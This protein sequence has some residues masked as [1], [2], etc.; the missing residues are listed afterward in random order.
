MKLQRLKKDMQRKQLAEKQRALKEAKKLNE[1]KQQKAA[2]EK[3]LAEVKKKQRE[4]EKSQKIAENLRI[5]KAK[6]AQAMEEQKQQAAA[7]ARKA[8][9]MSEAEKF[10]VLIVTAISKQWILPENVD[11]SLS[12]QFHIRLAPDGTV[13]D[14][15]LAQSSGDSILDRSAQTAIY[16]A[17]PLPVPTDAQLF[18]MFRSIRLTV[19]PE[20]VRG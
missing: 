2:E 10:K 16:K 3:R 6:E 11:D 20:N 4:V 14:V 13:L 18:E 8:Q 5:Q 7:R 17:S 12:S 9:M 15:Q 1:L 19:R